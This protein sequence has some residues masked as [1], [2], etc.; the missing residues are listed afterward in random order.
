MYYL[1]IDQGTTGSTAALIDSKTLQLI[2][3]VN[4]EFNQH[5][6]EPGMVEHDLGEIWVSIEKSVKELFENHSIDGSSIEAIGITNQ[7]ETT[8]A[9]Q[10]DGTPLARAIVWQDR[11][12]TSRCNDIKE[13]YSQTVK[14]KTGLPIDSYFSATKIEWLSENN[15]SVKNALKNN[16]CLFGTIDTYLIHKLS[17]QESFVTE[18]SNAS[19]T[20]IYNI[21]TNQW[22][23]ELLELFNIDI[24]TL[25]EVKDSFTHFGSTKGLS[26]LPDGIPISGCLGDQQSALFGQACFE[27][28]QSKCTYGTGA[29]FLTNTGKEKVISDNGLLSTIAYRHNGETFYAIEGSCYIAGAAVQWLR[30][31]LNIIGLASEIE[32][33]ANK[34]SNE[35][36]EHVMFLPFFTGIAS[37]YWNSDAKAAIIGLTR[38]TSNAE[39]SRAC[40][41]GIALSIN[42]LI[43]SVESDNGEKLKELQVDGGVVKN[44]L[45]LQMQSDF[46][47]LKIIRPKVIETTAYGAALAAAVG[48]GKVNFSD[49]KKLWQEDISLGPQ[50]TD[51]HINKQEMW[52][53]T[54]S[55]LY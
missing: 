9:F 27:K 10:K 7:R 31:N 1:S 41:E 16:D 43:K 19:R 55:K 15:D 21:N 18:A 3:K 25:A 50:T 35:K 17:G 13:Q 23:K 14:E 8:C 24:N 44:K 45:L 42:D 28:G 48:I 53:S 4:N 52:R 51:Y 54:I 37:P 32:F 46:S 5:F 26:I 12:T 20:M 34:S 38:D 2:G 47:E 29:F 30:D 11:R 36:I 6:P 40:L 39:I 49:I 33:L 22:D